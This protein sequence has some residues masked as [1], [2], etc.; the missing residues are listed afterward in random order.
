VGALSQQEEMTSVAKKKKGQRFLPR[1]GPRQESV[2]SR[3]SCLGPEGK[4]EWRERSRSRG[5]WPK[6]GG[7]ADALGK[8][9]KGAANPRPVRVR[10]KRRVTSSTAPKREWPNLHPDQKETRGGT[11]T[12]FK[13]A[14]REKVSQDISSLVHYREEYGSRLC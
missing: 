11:S 5:L 1:A 12:F 7:D 9:P 10:E 2:H 8:S 6:Q 14:V 4:E 3:S 13:L